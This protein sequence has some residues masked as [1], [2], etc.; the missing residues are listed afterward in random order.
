MSNNVDIQA[1][2]NLLDAYLFKRKLA[3][4]FVV[5]G[6]A[7]VELLGAKREGGTQDIDV[8]AREIDQELEKA[9]HFVAEKLGLAR[10]WLNQSA[11]LFNDRYPF[12]WEQRVVEVF[13]GKSLIVFSVGRRDLI[14][15]KAIAQL[16]RGFDLN[17]LI[18]LAPSKE[19]LSWLKEV[20]LKAKSNT[21]H[22]FD[23]WEID[24]LLGEIRRGL[25][26]EDND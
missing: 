22:L 4:E 9:A 25:D 5:G 18:A 13:T 6:G 20:L 23:R 10:N 3:R 2:L 12:G 1:A 16:D 17:D 24:E 21:G 8:V 19:D 14:I 26:Y 7:A 11:S 15:S